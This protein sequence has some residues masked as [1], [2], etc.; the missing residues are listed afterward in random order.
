MYFS[1]IFQILFI[2][3]STFLFFMVPEC[4][5]N[6]WWCFSSSFSTFEDRRR[7]SPKS[8]TVLLKIHSSSLW[9]PLIIV[10]DCENSSHTHPEQFMSLFS[11]ILRRPSFQK[12][13]SFSTFRSRS[14]FY[15]PVHRSNIL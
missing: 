9:H 13:Y 12:I 10:F 5:N 2:V 7:I 1:K 6:S 11:L 8:G 14:P 4:L 3:D 15:R